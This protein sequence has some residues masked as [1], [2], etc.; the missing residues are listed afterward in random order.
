MYAIFRGGRPGYIRLKRK[1]Y[2][3]GKHRDPEVMQINLAEAAKS[4][5]NND[6]VPITFTE[7]E[8]KE[9]SQ[10]HSDGLVVELEI[11][12]HKVMRNLIDR[13][14]SPDILFTRAFSLLNLLDR[15]L[16]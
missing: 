3:I 9:L 10:P 6:P 15:T 5:P 11:T 16:K 12:N 8:A 1:A 2:D 4:Y 13:G 7:D 14:S